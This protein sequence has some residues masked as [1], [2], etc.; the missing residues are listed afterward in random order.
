MKIIK[1]EE[2]DKYYLLSTF[3]S[4]FINLMKIW[5]MD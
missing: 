4:F 5:R 3:N 2:R 1:E